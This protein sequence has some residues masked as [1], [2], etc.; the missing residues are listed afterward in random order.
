MQDALLS[1][2]KDHMMD[3]LGVAPPQSSM[4]PAVPTPN[5]GPEALHPPSSSGDRASP[6]APHKSMSKQADGCSRSRSPSGDQSL[7]SRDGRSR[8][9]PHSLSSSSDRL[10]PSSKR[11]RKRW[12]VAHNDA[13]LLLTS[14]GA[15]LVPSATVPG[16][17]LL[18]V[19]TAVPLLHVASLGHVPP[20]LVVHPPPGMTR[21]PAR[22]VSLSPSRRSPTSLVRRSPWGRRTSPRTRRMSPNCRGHS[23][24]S[25]SSTLRHRRRSR[26][27]SSSSLSRSSSWDRLFRPFT[28][29]Q[30]LL[31]LRDQ[32]PVLQQEEEQDVDHNS[33]SNDNAM[34]AA[35]VRKLFADLVCPPALSL[36][37]DPFPDAPVA[38]NQLVPYVK[39]PP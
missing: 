3:L 9:R 28:A 13:N 18:T 20:S 39:G 37:A 22:D 2:M 1:S 29:E 25:R 32:S 12:A 31:R 15:A 19:T 7:S 5:M 17:L 14:V 8:R 26:S 33:S 10:S 30:Q 6:R 38:N 27:R 36:Y 4:G 16:L 23:S 11:L 21:R 24:C 34:S 35:A